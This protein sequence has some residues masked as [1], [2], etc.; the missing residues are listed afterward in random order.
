MKRTVVFIACLAVYLSA[1]AAPKSEADIKAGI[2][3]AVERYANAISCGGITVNPTDVLALTPYHEDAATLS[4]YAVLWSGDL[5]CFGGSGTEKT[6]L[7]IATVNT[8]HYVVQP[9]LSSPVAAFDMP[10]R[11]V[12]RVVSHSAGTLVLEGMTHGPNDPRSNP[13]IPVRFTLRE[14][15]SGAWKLAG[16]VDVVSK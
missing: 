12:K 4:K 1:S 2:A 16:T 9:E 7:A 8:G 3:N 6:R 14:D 11:F 5:G 10:V 15:A 13:S